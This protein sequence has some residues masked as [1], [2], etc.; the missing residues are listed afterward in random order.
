LM[1]KKLRTLAWLLPIEQEILKNKEGDA[2]GDRGIGD[3]K[4]R[5]M[6]TADIE[7]EE[8]DHKTEADPINEIADGP[9][10]NQGKSHG[11]YTATAAETPLGNPDKNQGRAGSA[12]KKDLTPESW[13]PGQDAEGSTVIGQIGQ[14]EEI[15]NDHF[16]LKEGKMIHN[17]NLGRLIDTDNRRDDEEKGEHQ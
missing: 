7:I 13:L 16:A 2:N 4:G 11:V 17:P 10:R 6:M 15:G 3:I 12:D 5:P 1:T 8:I 9:A 14:I